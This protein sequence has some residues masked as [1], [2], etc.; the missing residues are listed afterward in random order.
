[1]T[2]SIQYKSKLNRFRIIIA[3]QVLQ[4]KVFISSKNY[5]EKRLDFI[6]CGIEDLKLRHG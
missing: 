3:N 2:R 4:T 6:L 5:A 1:M